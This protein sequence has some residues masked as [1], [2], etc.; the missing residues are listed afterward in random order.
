MPVAV[1]VAVPVLCW[2]R[3]VPTRSAHREYRHAQQQDGIELDEPEG[4]RHRLQF[5]GGI[6]FENALC[7]FGVDS[8]EDGGRGAP[9]ARVGPGR[10]HAVDAMRGQLHRACRR[11]QR[12]QLIEGEEVAVALLRDRRAQQRGAAAPVGEAGEELDHL[13]DT[14]HAPVHALP[15]V[16]AIRKRAATIALCRAWRVARRGGTR[17]VLQRRWRRRRRRRRRGEAERL[18]PGWRWRELVEDV[19]GPLRPRGALVARCAAPLEGAQR[20]E[21]RLLPILHEPGLGR[22]ERLPICLGRL[23]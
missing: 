21:A 4:H 17:A 11:A 5:Q 18:A 10:E 16:A 12:L 6:E 9:A 13:L 7:Q 20:A 8:I 3:T 1:P 14:R 23:T 2:Y 15:R 19:V 22:A